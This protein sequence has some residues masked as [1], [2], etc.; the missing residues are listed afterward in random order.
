MSQQRLERGTLVGMRV[1]DPVAWFKGEMR[2]EKLES[3]E[4]GAKRRARALE[5]PVRSA[6]LTA[7]IWGAFMWLVE[8]RSSHVASVVAL[9]VVSIGFGF[10]MIWLAERTQRKLIR[11]E[12][13][14]NFHLTT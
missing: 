14:S 10:T 9:A 13:L 11:E 4:R 7:I 8:G 6:A 5:H 3:R 1:T 12:E 2:R